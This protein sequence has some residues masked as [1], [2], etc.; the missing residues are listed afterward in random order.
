MRIASL[1][2]N[3]F[4]NFLLSFSAIIINCSRDHISVV[5]KLHGSVWPKVWPWCLWNVSVATII[6]NLNHFD[7][8]DLTRKSSRT[9]FRRWYC[10]LRK[11]FLRLTHY[12][13]IAFF[14]L[15]STEESR[16]STSQSSSHS[17]SLATSATRS[18]GFGRHVAIWEL[19]C[20]PQRCWPPAPH[21]IRPERLGRRSRYGGPISSIVSLSSSRLLCTWSNM[22]IRLISICF[23]SP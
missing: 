18:I 17:S 7:I 23:W 13:D 11:V 15:Q 16:S 2:S 10:G 1:S 3:L 22:K 9:Y 12:I 21:S 6:W 5:F 19:R 4:S 8:V 14:F 20:M